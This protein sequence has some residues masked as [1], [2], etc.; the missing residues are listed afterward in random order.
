MGELPPPHLN[1]WF[2][3]PTR[4]LNPNVISI[5]AAVFAELTNASDRRTDRHTDRPTDKPRYS[6]GT[7]TVGLI[8]GYV[9]LRRGLL[10]TSAQRLID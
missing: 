4:V 9:V 10:I 1:T 8:Y 7:V 3:G 5:G 6:V 2:L